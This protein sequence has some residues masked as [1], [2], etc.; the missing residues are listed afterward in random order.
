MK[1]SFDFINSREKLNWAAKGLISGV[2]AQAIET[3]TSR[4]ALFNDKGALD[5]SHSAER[6]AAA[7]VNPTALKV[8]LAMLVLT[9]GMAKSMSGAGLSLENSVG[10]SVAIGTTSGA[11]SGAISEIDAQRKQPNFDLGK[12]VLHS[13]LQGASSGFGAFAGAKIGTF[14]ENALP[15]LEN[16]TSSIARFP[17]KAENQ[18]PER[19]NSIIDE[20]PH[21]TGKYESSAV[22]QTATSYSSLFSRVSDAFSSNFSADLIETEYI[23]GLTRW[24]KLGFGIRQYRTSNNRTGSCSS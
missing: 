22:V 8:D 1:A 13:V 7:L 4:D 9:H 24:K 20:Q 16:S 19:P 2:S 12:V 23:T 17:S 5:L 21:P 6:V 3:G 10:S 14:V 18:T 11:I 15:P